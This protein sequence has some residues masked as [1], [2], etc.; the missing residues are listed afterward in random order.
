MKSPSTATA[1][2]RTKPT[3]GHFPTD[4]ALIKLLYLGIRD[5]GRERVELDRRQRDLHLRQ[6]E[7]C[8]PQCGPQHEQH[9]HT[10]DGA[11]DE[12]PDEK[13]DQL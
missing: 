1:P 6:G 10:D 4:E 2:S 13:R 3:R 7:M 12:A 8:V 11:H 5:L 9:R